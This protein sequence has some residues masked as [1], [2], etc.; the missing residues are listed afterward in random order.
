VPRSR[1]AVALVCL[2]VGRAALAADYEYE[3]KQ[4]KGV[5]F[6]K[7][8]CSI[9]LTEGSWIK[10]EY[11]QAKGTLE[12][13]VVG[14]STLEISGECHKVVIEDVNLQ[15]KVDLKRLKIGA[16]GVLIKSVSGISHVHLGDCKGKVVIRSIN[17]QSVLH[18]RKGT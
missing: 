18:Y 8:E 14:K 11:K 13:T 17:L 3:D 4:M 6:N 1:I 5:K 2:L 15:S 10:G 16:G 12:L 9:K 7:A